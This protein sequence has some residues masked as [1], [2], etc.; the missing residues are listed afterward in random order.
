MRGAH[1][2]PELL[3]QTVGVR[4][5]QYLVGPNYERDLAAGSFYFGVYATYL[6]LVEFMAYVEDKEAW[7]HE[8]SVVSR[9]LQAWLHLYL[10]DDLQ[11]NDRS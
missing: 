1:P 9:D 4:P 7:A 11:G 10:G 8:L 2:S 3:A 5:G 6:L